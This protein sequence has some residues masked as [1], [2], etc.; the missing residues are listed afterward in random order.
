MRL[1][2]ANNWQG[3][4]PLNIVLPIYNLFQANY[5]KFLS[6]NP[7]YSIRNSAWASLPALTLSWTGQKADSQAA[8]KTQKTHL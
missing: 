2:T 1:T 4:L 8:T 7:P 3:S 6:Y 5:N